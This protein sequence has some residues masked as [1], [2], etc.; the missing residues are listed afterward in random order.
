MSATIKLFMVVINTAANVACVLVTNQP[1]SFQSNIYKQGSEP[2]QL[3]MSCKTECRTDGKADERVV[4]YN[5]FIVITKALLFLAR[6]LVST[7][8]FQFNFCKQEQWI[9][10]R[11][12][13]GQL[14]NWTVGQVHSWAVG[15][16]YGQTAGEMN[17]QTQNK[18]TNG[19]M[20]RQ[21]DR[22]KGRMSDRQM[23][24][25]NKQLNGEMDGCE[26][27]D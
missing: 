4:L 10:I 7:S 9:P 1:L 20:D 24:V 22:E 3:L 18:L 15:Q 13:V 6:V 25:T 8:N 27:K 12:I 2:T 16:A 14:H 19:Q 11:L 21:T 5:P 17:M 26:M 23:N